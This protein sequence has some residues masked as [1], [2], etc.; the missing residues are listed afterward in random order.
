[1]GK[2]TDKPTLRTNTR[3]GSVSLSLPM[4]RYSL[5]ITLPSGHTNGITALE[6]SPDGRFLASGSGDGVLLVFSTS[7]WKPVR[8]FVDAS[9]V[10]A[11]VW[12]PVMPKTLIAGYA[13]GDVHTAL[14]ASHNL[15][16]NVL[17]SL[18]LLH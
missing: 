18:R 4:G 9:S 5:D 17:F 14:F 8:R 13:S 1:M 11:L 12:H 2:L 7:T 3:C 10:N 16:M 6:F 15:V